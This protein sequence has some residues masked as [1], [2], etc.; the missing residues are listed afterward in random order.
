MHDRCITQPAHFS[1]ERSEG[2]LVA[3]DVFFFLQILNVVGLRCLVARQDGE[4]SHPR[5]LAKTATKRGLFD[6]AM[7]W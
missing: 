6:P 4:L 3:D 1:I 5:A 7:R 2:V